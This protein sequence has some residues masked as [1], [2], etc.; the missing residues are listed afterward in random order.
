MS[1]RIPLAVTIVCSTLA[2][3][4]MDFIMRTDGQVG[5]LVGWLV[6]CC[7]LASDV[8]V[9]GLRSLIPFFKTLHLKCLRTN[10]MEQRTRAVIIIVMLGSV[11][12]FLSLSFL[13]LFKL[14][15][16]P[17]PWSVLGCLNIANIYLIFSLL[18]V[19]SFFSLLGLLYIRHIN[20][21]FEAAYFIFFLIFRKP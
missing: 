21:I 13:L 2:Q 19:F 7:R 8:T 17:L 3:W 14:L 10:T 16:L 20:I 9:L 12:C 4:K 1:K 5:W 11:Y 6:V 18:V 15:L